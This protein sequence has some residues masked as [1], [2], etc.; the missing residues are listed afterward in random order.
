VSEPTTHLQVPCALCDRPT[1]LPAVWVCACGQYRVCYR[2]PCHMK[3]PAS[4]RD[5][6]C[7]ADNSSEGT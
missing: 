7:G 3:I 6:T 5:G 1:D 2:S 4:H